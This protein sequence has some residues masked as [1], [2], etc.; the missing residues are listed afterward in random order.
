M[1]AT[2]RTRKRR[3]P[4]APG[5]A[6]GYSLQVTRLTHL[7][8]EAA[9]GSHGSLEVIDDVG[10]VG[11]DGST[12][13]VQT[14]SALTGNPLGDHSVALWKTLA[15]WAD[16]IATA[17][18]PADKLCLVLYVSK[19]ASGPISQQLASATSDD[20]IQAA[21]AHVRTKLLSNGPTADSEVKEH[22]DRFFAHGLNVLKSVIKAFRIDCGSGSPQADLQQAL[23]NFCFRE[24]RARQLADMACGWVKSRVDELHERKLPAILSRDEFHRDMQAFYTKFVERSILISFAKA[25][26]P[27]DVETH[28]AKTFVRQ[29]EIIA[30]DFEDQMAAISN[31]FKAALDRTN[32]G[33]SGMVQ[34]ESFDEL[35]KNLVETWK[36]HQKTTAIRDGHRPPEH[37]GQL[38]LVEC[39]KHTAPVENLQ[40]PPHFIPGCFHVL[41]DDLKVGWHP[42]FKKLL[43]TNNRGGK[44]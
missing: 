2:R 32:W 17:N 1:S 40:A 5:Q 35:D 27:A 37:Q 4:S 20:E 10:V 23:D 9:E 30:V 16:A 33:V 28:R 7:L 3:S 18:L 12:T 24:G 43:A 36:N 31:Y 41:A 14:K 25:P 6:L 39:M 15:N 29:L 42:D 11:P 8:I 34:K 38:L 19:P 26:T 21:I 44:Q 13:A 22:I